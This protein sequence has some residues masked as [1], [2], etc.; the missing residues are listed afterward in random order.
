MKYKVINPMIYGGITYNTGQEVE[1]FESDVAK[2]CIERGI[3]EK[4]AENAGNID[5]NEGNNTGETEKNKKT[6]K[7]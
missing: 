4:I 7:K 5:N 6:T 3:I 1:I 2:S